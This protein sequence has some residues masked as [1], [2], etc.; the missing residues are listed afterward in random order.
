M[1]RALALLLLTAALGGIA[2]AS[3]RPDTESRTSYSMPAVSALGIR[4]DTLLMGGYASGTFGEAVRTIASDLSPDE[5]RLVARHLERIFADVVPADGL[6]RSGRLRVAYE[7]ARRPDGTTRSIRVLS[8]ELASEGR[9]HTAFYF[10]RAGRP[11]YY[12]PFGLALDPAAWERPLGGSRVSSPFG[13]RRLHPILNQVLPHTGVDF[14]APSGTTVR[15]TAD[16]LVT[17]AGP[18]G[19]YGLLVELQHPSGYATRYAH[20]SRIPPDLARAPLVRQGDIIGFVGMT[21]LATGPH[22]HYEVRRRGQ[23]MDPERVTAGAGIAS[24]IAAEPRWPLE[25]R[26]LSS[27]LARAPTMVASSAPHG[28]EA[29]Q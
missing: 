21:G 6:G 10:E 1:N 25:R 16:G 24:T 8:V 2:A 27:L 28:R 26:A 9:I 23:P 7:R 4:F 5:G 22:L 18:R 3:A 12:D 17:H 29:V 11:G 14:A 15:A 20:L 13:R 19:G